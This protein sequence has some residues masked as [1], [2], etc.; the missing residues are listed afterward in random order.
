MTTPVYNTWIPVWRPNMRVNVLTAT[1][2][3]LNFE[4]RGPSNSASVFIQSSWSSVVYKLRHTSYL[5]S[6]QKLGHCQCHCVSQ[7]NDTSYLLSVS[8]PV[9]S[10]QWV[11]CLQFECHMSNSQNNCLTTSWD[12]NRLGW[13]NFRSAGLKTFVDLQLGSL[14][15]QTENGFLSS[16]QKVRVHKS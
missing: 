12:C 2:N 9:A 8:A 4:F 13:R 16:N 1:T 10:V 7:L 11:C 15:R 6:T 5:E 14:T 3:I